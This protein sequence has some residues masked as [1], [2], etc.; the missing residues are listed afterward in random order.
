[1]KKKTNTIIS[2]SLS[3][4]SIKGSK[5]CNS[6]A[7]KLKSIGHLFIFKSATTLA[8]VHEIPKM[9]VLFLS[10]FLFVT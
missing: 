8:N 1:M 5:S 2:L 7:I 4:Q 10:Q 9:N 6:Q 3:I